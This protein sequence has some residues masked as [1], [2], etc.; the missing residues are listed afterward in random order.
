M[1]YT[2]HSFCV[3]YSFHIPRIVPI[4]PHVLQTIFLLER[5][6]VLSHIHSTYMHLACAPPIFTVIHI[7]ST[8]AYSTNSFTSLL[9]FLSESNESSFISSLLRHSHA[10]SALSQAPHLP[11]SPS[12]HTIHI[13][14]RLTTTESVQ[15]SNINFLE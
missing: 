11:L 9:N 15:Y 7:R 2:T 5:F 14:L 10:V 3:I 8:F 13:Y 4:T 6:A 1:L 12:H